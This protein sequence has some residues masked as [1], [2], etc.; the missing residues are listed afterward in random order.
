[1]DEGDHTPRADDGTDQ[2]DDDDSVDDDSDRSDG[3]ASDI[4]DLNSD[5]PPGTGSDFGDGPD[6]DAD[7]SEDSDRDSG[8]RSVPDPVT[9][10]GPETA[11][12]DNGSRD[13]SS[14][15]VD[16]DGVVL[17]DDDNQGLFDDLLSGE[18]IFENKEVLRPSYTPHELP[19]RNDQINR[20]ATILVSALRGE[21]PSNILIYGK[22]GTGKTASA[23]FVS[24]ELE[25]TSQKY[26]VP[27]EVEYINCEVTDTQY[28][29]LAQLANTFIE[30]NQAVIA[31]QLERLE[32]LRADATDADETAG[33]D[34]A[35]ALADTEF[36]SIEDL[37]D[38]IETL[39][40]DADEMEEVPMTG[41]PTDRVYS[42]FFEA[43]DYHERVVVIML[44]EIDKLVEKSGDDTLYNLSRMNSELNRSRI[45]IMGISNDLKF[46]DFLDPR[47]KSSLGEEEI[48]FPPYDANQ[49]RDILQHRADTAFKPDAL[50]DDVIPLCAAFAAQEHGDARRALDLLR[51]AGELAERSQAE[52]VAEKHVRQ[53]QDKI[54]LDRVV[55]VVRTLPTQSK[56]V[57]FAVILL[58]KNGVHNINTGEVF[59]I[60]KRLCEEI[61]ADVLTQRRVTDL[62][63]ELDMLGIVN[64]VVVSKGRYGRTKEM[65]LSVPVEETEAVLL[66]DSRLGD[67]ENAQ[68]FVQARFDN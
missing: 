17:D 47:V 29:V 6:R 50:T 34:A 54:E 8:S 55:E 21:T 41:W 7:S 58:E 12:I 43:V 24:Q 38:R 40:D 57:L 63:S 9:D 52:I 10:A 51:T 5:G 16:F 4:A 67:I 64:A 33:R 59:N 28:R 60:Y 65:G 62:I 61:D 22:T 13:R 15:D 53:A 20:M 14:P 48:V 46:T 35:A 19:H 45:S 32:G 3:S 27:C 37:D 66:S 49:L 25:S 31:D 68:P 36:D 44:D 23:K 30:E 26:D 1:M 2:T 18:P 42:T 11:E 39:E 56:I